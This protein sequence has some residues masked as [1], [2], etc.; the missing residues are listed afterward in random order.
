[1]ALT[2]KQV[3]LKATAD[4]IRRRATYPAETFY[5]E[6]IPKILRALAFT[7]SNIEKVSTIQQ[8]Q[9][10]LASALEAGLS[11]TQWKEIVT[12][13]DSE[14]GAAL[15]NNKKV[16]LQ[17]VYRNAM[18]GAYASGGYDFAKENGFYLRYFAVLDSQTRPSHGALDGITLPADDPFWNT[19]TPI[20]GHNC[21]CTV[22]SVSPQ[23]ARSSKK[24]ITAPKQIENKTG[25]FQ[26]TGGRDKGFSGRPYT[27]SQKSLERNLNSKLDNGTNAVSKDIKAKQSQ[28]ERVANV[29]FEKNKDSFSED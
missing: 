20:L 3:A 18:N 8:I 1:M 16:R 14:L 12:A 26:D 28:S 24:S 19:H 15:E 6:T 11:F 27:K 29:W 25:K 9:A 13:Q 23:F 21:R 4:K 7:V 2:A 22:K 10:S 5:S 17:L